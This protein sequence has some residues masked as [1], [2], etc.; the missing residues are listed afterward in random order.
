MKIIC[1]K[2][3]KFGEKYDKEDMTDLPTKSTSSKTFDQLYR[4]L[5]GLIRLIYNFLYEG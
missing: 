4:R 1:R 3:Y 2:N 5:I